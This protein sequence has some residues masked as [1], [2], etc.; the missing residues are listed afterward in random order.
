M[1]RQGI[2][3][4]SILL[5]IKGDDL[6]ALGDNNLVDGSC[7]SQG[8]GPAFAL[9]AGIGDNL[10]VDVIL[11]KEPLSAYARGSTFAV[12]HPVDGHD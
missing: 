6:L 10:H 11:L 7:K 9:F 1:S 12:V 2:I 3:I 4:R 8:F 5:H